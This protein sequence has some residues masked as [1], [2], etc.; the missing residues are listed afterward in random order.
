[1]KKTVKDRDEDLNDAPYC[2]GRCEVC[3][4]TWGDED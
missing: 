3:D 1:M 4:K 2:D